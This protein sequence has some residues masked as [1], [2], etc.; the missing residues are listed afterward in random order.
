M[1]VLLGGDYDGTKPICMEKGTASFESISLG[2]RVTGPRHRYKP[3]EESRGLWLAT[4]GASCAL[5][6]CVQLARNRRIHRIYCHRF[7]GPSRRCQFQPPNKAEPGSK[8]IL[9]QNFIIVLNL[10]A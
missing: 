10:L 7:L 6:G 9:C 4:P 5:S 2:L 1:S 8:F 3:R